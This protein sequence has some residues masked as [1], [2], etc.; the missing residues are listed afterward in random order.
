MKLHRIIES[1]AGKLILVAA[2]GGLVSVFHD[3]HDPTPAPGM[4]GAC[5]D[6]AAGCGIDHGLPAG[7]PEIEISRILDETEHQLGAYFQGTRRCFDLPLD[8]AGT[9]FQR[10]VWSEIAAVPYGETRSYKELAEALGN[11]AMGRA[12]GAAV[13]AN[14]LSIIV[15]GHRVVGS[16]GKVLG[17]AAGGGVKRFLLD[18]E[19]EPTRTSAESPGDT[20][21]GA[22][23]APA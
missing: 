8:A 22:P 5:F 6:P 23:G 16:T 11:R 14:P 10:H 3:H 17:Y 9:D 12:V 13:R 20:G 19:A 1:P 15:P 2:S 4:L 18:L 7:E 21:K